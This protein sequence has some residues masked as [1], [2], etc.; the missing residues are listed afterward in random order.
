MKRLSFLILACVALLVQPAGAGRV[1]FKGFVGR[2]AATLLEGRV[3]SRYARED[4]MDEAVRAF[5]TR[6]DDTKKPGSGYWQGEFWGKTMLGHVGAFRYTGRADVRD[7]VLAQASR[8]VGGYMRPDGYLGTYNDPRFVRGG[9]NIWGRKYTLWALVEAYEAT[10]ERRILDAAAKTADQI[11]AMIADMK[12]PLRETG[13]FNGCCD[14]PP[15]RR[16]TAR[17]WN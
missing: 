15:E 4:V 3:F 11:V 9:W 5:E 7:Y 2:K 6:Y 1:E 13:C 14:C 17:Q 12:I 10:G 8:L 16:W